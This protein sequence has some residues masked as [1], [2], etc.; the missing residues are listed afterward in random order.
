MS[1]IKNLIHDYGEFKLNI[2]H[3]EL[4]DK[5]ITALIGP[6]GSG[7]TSCF[8]IL[9][10]LD[11]CKTL[12][13]IFKGEDLALQPVEKRNLGVVFQSYQLFP[14]LTAMQNILFAVKARGKTKA[15]V[16][17]V[18]DD[19]IG[20][21]DIVSILDRKVQ[22]LSGGEQQR[23]ALA[24]ALVTLPIFLFLDEPFSALDRPLRREA[25][26]LVQRTIK[27][28]SIPTL[29]ITHDD[30]DVSDLADEVVGIKNGELVL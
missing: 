21:L 9:L 29:L 18:Y 20:T 10:G 12:Q 6:S 4:S 24:R 25:R 16:Q 27:R 1:L 28:F 26:A 23:V 8:R 7:K 14:H 3:W 5:G 15:D 2:P 13:W 17:E 11:P 30:E 19:L 22:K